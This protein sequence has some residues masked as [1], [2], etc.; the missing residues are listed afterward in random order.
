[1]IPIVLGALS[2]LLG[3]MIVVRARAN[4]DLKDLEAWSRS[5][6]ETGSNPPRPT[7]PDAATPVKLIVDRSRSMAGFIEESDQFFATLQ[8]II[9]AFGGAEIWSYALS[10]GQASAEA[11]QRHGS[12]DMSF[13]RRSA[14]SGGF[15]DDAAILRAHDLEGG[16]ALVL[17][18][19]GVY[20][21]PGGPGVEPVVEMFDRILDAGWYLGIITLDADFS[22]TPEETPCFYSEAKRLA[23]SEDVLLDLPC[24]VMTRP[25]YA[26]IIDQT[27]ERFLDLLAALEA[28]APYLVGPAAMIPPS[29]KKLFADWALTL[30]GVRVYLGDG[31]WTL[32]LQ[33][34]AA[35]VHVRLAAGLAPHSP[36][37]D[38]GWRLEIAR[39]KRGQPPNAAWEQV[40]TIGRVSGSAAGL[41]RQHSNQVP[42][43]WDAFASLVADLG[44][45]AT[46]AAVADDSAL[47]SWR[48][49]HN[50]LERGA[51]FCALV[52]GRP[53]NNA[54]RLRADLARGLAVR[55]AI[56]A[57]DR[58][59]AQA[60][61]D[62][63]DSAEIKPRVR[64]W[65]EEQFLEEPLSLL[66][67]KAPGD[68]S[69]E[70]MPE[71]PAGDRRVEGPSEGALGARFEIDP[72][73]FSHDGAYLYRLRLVP[74]HVRLA[75]AIV[76]RSTDDDAE[77]A[78]VGRT[79]RLATWIEMLLRARMLDDAE[80]FS[81]YLAIPNQT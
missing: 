31:N 74:V 46:S 43:R 8:Q 26:L 4:F 10:N 20:S 6:F 36:V 44:T 9:T 60:Y 19:D 33:P 34:P 62:E 75:D 17:V 16:Q 71:A 54:M 32:T 55:H 59:L 49:L 63:I 1:M 40:D 52:D 48:P 61:A 42:W 24:P 25:L 73:V 41:P 51:L 27:P 69:V 30:D 39:K 76:R 15:N 23:G 81:L 47:G 5:Q 14:Y 29:P 68:S 72:A 80:S 77:L 53:V 65:L 13:R 22:C 50:A 64:Q 58:K 70:A 7:V 38:V 28:S 78:N 67:P 57:G 21:A 56:T 2:V 35:A 66:E 45:L 18:T 79:F 12:L 37:A 11:W 3:L